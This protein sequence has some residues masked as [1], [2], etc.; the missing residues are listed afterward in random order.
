MDDDVSGVRDD[1]DMKASADDRTINIM[2]K[3]D[4]MRLI[5]V[6]Y[7]FER[8]SKSKRAIVIANRRN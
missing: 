3:R 6:V 5:V 1:G 4:R 8:K 7:Y 2:E